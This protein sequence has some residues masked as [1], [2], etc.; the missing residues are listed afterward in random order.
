MS[1]RAITDVWVH[2]RRVV[3]HGRLV[4]VDQAA[5]MANVRAVTTGWTL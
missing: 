3:E 5:L 1:A 2:G 4:M